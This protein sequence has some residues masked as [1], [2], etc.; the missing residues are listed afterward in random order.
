MI[1]YAELFL[2]IVAF[3]KNSFYQQVVLFPATQTI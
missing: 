1:V 3:T 2:H